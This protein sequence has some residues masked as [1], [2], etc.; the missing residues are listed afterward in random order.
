MRF[1]NNLCKIEVQRVKFHFVT[2]EGKSLHLSNFLNMLHI[3]DSEN[4]W[5]LP[6]HGFGVEFYQIDNFAEIPCVR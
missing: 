2:A 3:R 5:I 4:A 6:F 1:L